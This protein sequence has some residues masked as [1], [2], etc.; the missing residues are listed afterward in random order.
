MRAS[1]E[2]N[3]PYDVVGE[4]LHDGCS[5][6]GNGLFAESCGHAVSEG[7]EML[8]GGVINRIE[9]GAVEMSKGEL[10][11]EDACCIF[12]EDNRS[13]AV[14]KVRKSERSEAG[15]ADSLVQK[16]RGGGRGT[17]LLRR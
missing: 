1:D 8:T 12:E 10:L 15:R 4:G 13:K 17:T 9:E 11:P 14:F 3:V 16:E 5:E 6:G 7:Q 2:Y